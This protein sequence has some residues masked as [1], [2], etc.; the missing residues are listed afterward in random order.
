M[1]KLLLLICVCCICVSMGMMAND[2][3]YF[4]SGNVLFPLQETTISV[5]NEVLSI[6]ICDDGYATID[7]QYTFFND[8]PA[9]TID[10]VSIIVLRPNARAVVSMQAAIKA[11]TI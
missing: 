3:A 8:G 4:A 7:V 6:S 11:I 9:K 2:G 1:R 10:M 5:R